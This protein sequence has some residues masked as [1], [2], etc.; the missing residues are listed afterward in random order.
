[1]RPAGCCLG[2]SRVALDE[3]HD[4]DA[5]LEAR[6]A[7]RELGKEQHRDQQPSMPRVAVL[8]EASRRP[9]GNVTRDAATR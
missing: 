4:R 5:G 9:V 2:V 6:Q 1:M 7:E 8:A 3:R